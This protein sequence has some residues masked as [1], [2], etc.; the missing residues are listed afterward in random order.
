[1]T[2]AR[3]LR[4]FNPG[5]IR[6]YPHAAPWVGQTGLDAWGMCIFDTMANGVRALARLLIT[7]QRSHGLST[8]RGIVSRWAPP[9][10]NDTDAYIADVC[11]RTG[12]GADLWLDV[13]SAD[14]L[15]KLVVAIAHHENG[16]VPADV[17][18]DAGIARALA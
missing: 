9:N 18:I 15:R 7:Y 10:E 17:D 16:T 8:V 5:N 11:Q 4:N 13:H 1:M 2:T 14:T 3:G 6:G 12:F